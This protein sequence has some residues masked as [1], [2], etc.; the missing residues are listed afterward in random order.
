MRPFYKALRIIHHAMHQNMLIKIKR[1]DCL[2]QYPAFPLRSYDHDKDEELIQYP[3][4][5]N[6]YTLTLAS[7]SFKGHIKALGKALQ[8]LTAHLG[9]MDLI[10]LGDTILPWLYQEND[11]KPVVA[12]QQYLME[13]K[14]GKRFNG[15]IQV[16]N[17]LLVPFIQHLSW[18]T[19]C[20]ASLPY[21]Y[22]TDKGQHFIGHI[23]KHGNLHLDTLHEAVDSLIKAG[24]NKCPFTYLSSSNCSNQF[25]KTS[26]IAGRR[27][28]AI[29]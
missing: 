3:K 21:F 23:C 28:I 1:Q 11:Y 12:A 13:N 4:T 18:L 20:N 29:Q 19:R 6:S 17:Q 24:I 5:F 10:F 2:E 25:G 9:Y 14:I 26:A 8:Q 16:N 15:A 22:F 27:I 7:K